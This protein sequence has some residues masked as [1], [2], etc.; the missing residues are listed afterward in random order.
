MCTDPKQLS[1]GTQLKTLKISIA[2][3]A[4]EWI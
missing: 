2:L 4:E 3:R 1:K